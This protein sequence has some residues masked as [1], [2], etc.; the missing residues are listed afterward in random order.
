LS[1][2]TWEA[3]REHRRRLKA[4]MTPHAERLVLGKLEALG[5]NP[6]ALVEQAIERGWKT[7]FPLADSGSKRKANG[8]DE[9]LAT[10]EAIEGSFTREPS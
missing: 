6:E 9:W 5:G 2:Q 3:F 1:A 8:I 4:S 7:V 10:Q